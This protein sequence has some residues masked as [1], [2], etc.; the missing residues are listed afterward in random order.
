MY[1]RYSFTLIELLVV[2]AII[3]ILAS[4]LL[5][6]LSKARERANAIVCTNS[7]K[8][9]GTGSALYS[10]EHDDWIVPGQM[11]SS[12][13]DW[14]RLL[15]GRD[16]SNELTGT[17]YGELKHYGYDVRDSSFYCP[18]EKTPFGPYTSIPPK[19]QY[20]HY[21]L[22]RRLSGTHAAA[23]AADAVNTYNRWRKLSHIIKPTIAISVGDNIV[24][25]LNLSYRIYHFAFRH[26]GNDNRPEQRPT[27]APAENAGRANI[28]YVAGNVK[29]SS[30]KELSVV[31]AEHNQ[32]ISDYSSMIA[33]FRWDSGLRIVKD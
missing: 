26:G 18:S 2:I 12:H 8:Q 33:G 21:A 14:I 10:A 31:P 22:N 3:A 1:S 23:G 6:A 13:D 17:V 20:S 5:P 7:L 16:K 30:Y 4:L 29:P 28:L 24:K 19:Y 27:L 9:I 25:D 15:C 32:S 11:S